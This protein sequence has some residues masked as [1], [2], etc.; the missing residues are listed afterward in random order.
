ML[1]FNLD[2]G[3]V[4]DSSGYNRDFIVLNEASRTFVP[5]L[6][7]NLAPEGYTT[8]VDVDWTNILNWFGTNNGLMQSPYTFSIRVQF[9]DSPPRDTVFMRLVNKE[10]TEVPAGEVWFEWGIIDS[11]LYYRFKTFG[12]DEL[13]YHFQT[14]NSLI[15]NN[16]DTYT[17]KF[18]LYN[19][20]HDGMFGYSL[21]GGS[22]VALSTERSM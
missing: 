1:K 5:S 12:S 4:A 10:T 7:G 21:N 9:S 15:L 14:Q 13:T 22:L 6:P 18:I 17:F 3:T 11:K 19:S 20:G 16:T 8:D 2:S